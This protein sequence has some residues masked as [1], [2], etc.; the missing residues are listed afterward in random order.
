M[1]DPL[2]LSIVIVSYN[3]AAL[4]LAC[5]ES[6]A[7]AD[8]DKEIHVVDNASTDGCPSL[9]NESFLDVYLAANQTKRG[10]AAANNQALPHCTG[11]NL[12]FSHPDTVVQKEALQT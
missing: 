1:T 12:V 3:T 5:L 11:R 7:T 2:A 9:I 4:T 8:G 10:F 6:L